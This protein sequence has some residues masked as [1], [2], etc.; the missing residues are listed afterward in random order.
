VLAVA[1]DNELVAA[2]AALGRQVVGRPAELS[3]LSV[4]SDRTVVRYGD[5]VL[6]AHA[7]DTDPAEL[8]ARLGIAAD[9]RLADVWLPP[10][11]MPEITADDVNVAPRGF[12]GRVRGRLVTAWSA[13]RALA[14]SDAD[15]VPWEQA[16]TTLARLHAEPLMPD[17]PAAGVGRRLATAVARLT[18]L[19]TE[20][21]GDRDRGAAGDDGGDSDV[22]AVLRAFRALPAWAAGPGHVRGSGRAQRS[23]REPARA[24]APG[25]PGEPALIHGDWHLGQLVELA[26]VGWRFVDVDDLGAG[27]P[28]WDLA[29]PAAWFAA[30]LVAPELWARFVDAYRR[31]GG[32]AL[33]PDGDP[34][35]C[36]D[37]PARAVTVQYAATA[38]LDRAETGEE[39]D[40]AA[41]AVVACCRRMTPVRHSLAHL[42]GTLPTSYD[43][44][45]V[46]ND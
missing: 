15:S 8:A 29:R 4:R 44:Q 16:A 6:K 46:P 41:A 23:G 26:D 42:L 35:A 17:V 28:V 36:L 20:G 37:V 34:W 39:L 27:D 38:L 14:P 33:A 22:Q 21:D 18:R 24:T 9:P 3:V 11:P 19:P 2:M 12:I 30:G 32:V 25:R 45:D 10:L 7:A 31:A 1:Q 40:D 5:V 13:G 43:H